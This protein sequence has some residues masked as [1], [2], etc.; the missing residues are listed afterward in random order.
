[1]KR[2][3]Q[4]WTQARI[5][6]QCKIEGKPIPVLA[7]HSSTSSREI[8]PGQFKETAPR[9]GCDEHKVVPM[10]YL[11][12]GEAITFDQYLQREATCQQ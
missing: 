3:I 11:L 6:F 8:A 2:T 7:T 5:C 10:V 9:Y 12:T 1:M 4:K